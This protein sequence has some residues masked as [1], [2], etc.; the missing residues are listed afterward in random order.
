MGAY[1]KNPSSGAR[2][3]TEEFRKILEDMNKPKRG[4]N[5]K[6]KVS[7]SEVVKTRKTKIKKAARKPRSPSPVQEVS[8]SRT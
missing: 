2:P 5:R 3:I 6:E 8:D 1:L 7:T 4:G